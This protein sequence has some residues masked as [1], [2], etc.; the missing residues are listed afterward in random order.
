MIRYLTLD[1]IIALQVMTIR[2]HGGLAGV[3]DIGLVESAVKQPEAAFGGYDLYPTIVE[4]AA[5]TAIRWLRTTD[6]SME[7]SGSALQ[8]SIHSCA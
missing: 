8:H 5:A 1:Q 3:R 6:S 7:T 4:K 2:T